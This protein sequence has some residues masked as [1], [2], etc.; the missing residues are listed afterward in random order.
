M[1]E[2]NRG[3]YDDALYKSTYT[4]ICNRLHDIVLDRD[5]SL[6]LP[7]WFTCDDIVDLFSRVC[8]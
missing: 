3:S 8:V 2:R 1:S 7:V 6:T 5:G 4:L